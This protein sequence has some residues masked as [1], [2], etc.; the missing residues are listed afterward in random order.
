MPEAITGQEDMGDYQFTTKASAAEIT[1]YYE[2]EMAKLKW[3]L[4]PDMMTKVPGIALSF[5][6]GN[7]FIFFKIE[8]QG[9]NNVVY[10]HLVQM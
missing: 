2:Q 9:Q 1:T 8:S 5:T 6:K 10:I 4:S 7:T 3:T